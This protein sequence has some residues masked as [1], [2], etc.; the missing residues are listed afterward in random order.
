MKPCAR[1]LHPMASQTDDDHNV[2]SDPVWLASLSALGVS[3]PVCLSRSNLLRLEG[4]EVMTSVPFKLHV[5]IC[6]SCCCYS[7]KRLIASHRPAIMA[8][9]C[10]TMRFGSA[11]QVLAKSKLNYH[12]ISQF[13]VQTCAAACCCRGQRSR[14]TGLNLAHC[15]SWSL[16]RP[17]RTAANPSMT[18]KPL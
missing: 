12:R 4:K 3:L 5:S 7:G 18:G 8:R 14:I 13:A 6:K 11:P 15:C 2:V 17:I 10:Y 1:K 9:L 16:P